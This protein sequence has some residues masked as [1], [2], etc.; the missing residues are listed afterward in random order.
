MV[1]ESL[2]ASDLLVKSLERW[3][4]EFM[5]DTNQVKETSKTLQEGL[6]RSIAVP[7]LC[8][9]PSTSLESELFCS[10]TWWMKALSRSLSIDI[11]QQC[12]SLLFW[13]WVHFTWRKLLLLSLKLLLLLLQLCCCFETPSNNCYSC[14]FLRRVKPQLDFWFHLKKKNTTIFSS[15]HSLAFFALLVIHSF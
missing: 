8:R 9:K 13:I 7:L 3:Y 10:W 11:E 14:L 5:K 15:F 6:H 12:T 1:K 4:D 2:T